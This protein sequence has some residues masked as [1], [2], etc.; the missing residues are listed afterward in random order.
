MLVHGE[1][2]KA[3]RDERLVNAQ[4]SPAT[5]WTTMITYIIWFLSLSLAV[6]SD[7]VSMDDSDNAVQY[8]PVGK[9]FRQWNSEGY[10]V[11]SIDPDRLSGRT[12]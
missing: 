1:C 4:P 6:L 12:L 5:L 11:L 2:R 7:T 8:S 10:P 9:W 3:K